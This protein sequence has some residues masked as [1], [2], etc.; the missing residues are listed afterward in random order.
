MFGGFRVGGGG[1]GG[2]GAVCAADGDGQRGESAVFSDETAGSGRPLGFG[3]TLNR[4]GAFVEVFQRSRG[5]GFASGFALR[6]DLRALSFSRRVATDLAASVAL[7]SALSIFCSSSSC[8]INSSR[9]IFTRGS[10]S[11]VSAAL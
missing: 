11:T 3:I 9:G 4:F 2:G 8:R 5:S 10:M 6:L 7:V 1:C